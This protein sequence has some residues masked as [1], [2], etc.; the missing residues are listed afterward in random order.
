MSNPSETHGAFS[1]MELHCND[2]GKAKSFYTSLLGWGSETV[3]VGVGPYTMV[4]NG[5]EKDRRLAGHAGGHA[6]LAALCHGR[7]CRRP[8]RKRRG[9]SVRP[10]PANRWTFRRSAASPSSTILSAA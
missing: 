5:G 10:S 4:T 2:A 9:P 1:W 8:C 3:D 7:R 6:P